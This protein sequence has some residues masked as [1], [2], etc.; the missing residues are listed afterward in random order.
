MPQPEIQILKFGGTSVAGLHQWQ[1]IADLCQQRL[2]AGHR[3]LLVCSAISGVTDL[4]ELMV[5]ACKA[6]DKAVLAGYL[7]ALKEQH[8]QLARTLGIDFSAELEATIERLKGYLADGNLSPATHAQILA[9]GEYLSTRLGYCWLAQQS[10]AVGWLAAIDL[11]SCESPAGNDWR[12]YLQADAVAAVNCTQDLFSDATP[13]LITQ[14]FIAESAA[15][16]TCLLG[17]GGS[18]I[19]AILMASGLAAQ[20]VEIY[21]DVPGVFSA[22]PHLCDSA[23]LL[24]ELDYTEALEIAA[25]GAGVIHPR[26]IRCAQDHGIEIQM[27]QTGTAD[28]LGTR[29]FEPNFPTLSTQPVKAIS[30]RGNMLALLLESRDQNRQVGFLAEVFAVFSKHGLAIEQVATSETTTTL[31]LHQ[32][33][34]RIDEQLLERLSAALSRHCK[35]TLLPPATALTVIGRGIRTR[36]EAITAALGGFNQSRLLMVSVSAN[37]IACTLLVPEADSHAYL[38]ALHQKLIESSASVIPVF[39]PSW[40]ALQA[41][42]SGVNYDPRNAETFHFSSCEFDPVTGVATLGYRFDDHAEFFE[43][44]SFN[45]EGNALQFEHTDAHQAF[46]NALHILHLIA[47]VSY[48]KAGI[49]TR[50]VVDTLATDKI[51]EEF[52]VHLY[53]HGLAEFA[54]RNAVDLRPR[55]NFEFTGCK[56]LQVQVLAESNQSD[57]LAMGGGKDSLVAAELLKSMD[58]CFTTVAVGSSELIE[59][60]AKLTGARFIRIGRT[61]APKLQQLNANGALNGHVPVTAIN[62][63]I[64]VCQGLL[65]GYENVIFANESSAS[66]PNLQGD[67]GEDINHQYSKGLDYEQRFQSLLQ[68]RVATRPN[69]FSLLRPW[70]ELA[71]VEEFSRYP[72]YFSAFSSCNR[73]FHLQGSRIGGRWC[74]DCPKCRFASLML[75][76]WLPR[77]QVNEIIGRDMLADSGQVQGFAQLCGF[78]GHKPFECVGEV[79]ESCIAVLELGRRQEYHDSPVVSALMDYVRPIADSLPTLDEMLK[80]ADSH[81]MPANFSKLIKDFSN[82]TE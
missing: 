20:S 39:G 46:M 37:D 28:F 4:L 52:L 82:A 75:S 64:L 49:P 67:D 5:L 11:L 80:L 55:L 77:K 7:V 24:F 76:L 10:L 38:L 9:T 56:R 58:R 47:G 73:N 74:G 66:S 8:L 2:V 25:S 78:E 6:Q 18:D 1:F 57:L 59:T 42:A 51:L 22:N 63:A 61:L 50:L 32:A 43:T 36:L 44:I 72:Q 33:E 3:L 17:R 30:L 27:R 65:G 69:C 53:Q 21:S 60:T 54:H 12:G 81:L 13:L 29:I 40:T 79:E 34:N 48:Y 70:R 23:R 16:E 19:S 14:G 31:S 62:A 35:L 71:I 45:A 15:G 41:Q 68:A 26:A